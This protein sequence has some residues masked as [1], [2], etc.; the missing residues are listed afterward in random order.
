[1]HLVR[2]LK[3]FWFITTWN[4][5]IPSPSVSHSS[6]RLLV[7]R[8]APAKHTRSTKAFI[9][10]LSVSLAPLS[11]LKSGWISKNILTG[12]LSNVIKTFICN[13]TFQCLKECSGVTC[14]ANNRSNFIIIFCHLRGVCVDLFTLHYFVL[15]VR[16]KKIVSNLHIIAAVSSDVDFCTLP[17]T[18]SRFHEISIAFRPV[19]NAFTITYIIKQFHCN[20]TVGILS[21][22]CVKAN[23]NSRHQLTPHTYRRPVSLRCKNAK[24]SQTNAIRIMNPTP[25]ALRSNITSYA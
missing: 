1:M 10:V 16:K 18:F 13:E 3:R 9:P 25:Q 6:S 19:I 2:N 23:H 20:D 12:V 22:T 8:S 21:I 5:L 14:S 17:I 15:Y 24:Y 11:R 4:F 7:L